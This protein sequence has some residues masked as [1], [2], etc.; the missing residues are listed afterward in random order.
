MKEIQLSELKKDLNSILMSISRSDQSVL[1]ADK[2]RLLVRIVPVT[3]AAKSS[4]LGS[5]R[6]TG[7]IVGDIV[8]P[9]EEPDSWEVLAE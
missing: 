7:K 9:V 5:M 3:P 6:G 2:E 8:S 1:I 4:W